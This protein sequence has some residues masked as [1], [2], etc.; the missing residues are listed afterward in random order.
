[1]AKL[2]CYFLGSDLARVLDSDLYPLDYVWVVGRATGCAI[3]FSDPLVSKQHARIRHDEESGCWQVLDAGSTNGTYRNGKRLDPR[4]WTSIQEGDRLHFGAPKARI[5]FSYDIDETL[6]AENDDDEPTSALVP[7]QLPTV[8]PAATPP[9]EPS[10]E[11]SRWSVIADV[12]DW[13][14]NPATLSGGM[15]RLVILFA[16]LATVAIVLILR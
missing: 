10:K 4:V 2:A 7:G 8:P 9:A 12:V 5:R 1:M 6:S 3:H 14:Q 16:F 13:I 15:Y 11:H